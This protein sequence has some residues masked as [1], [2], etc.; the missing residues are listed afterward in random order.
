MLMFDPSTSSSQHKQL[1]Y[2]LLASITS[3]SSSSSSCGEVEVE[4]W[5]NYIRYL[6]QKDENF[7][8]I[9]RLFNFAFNFIDK[10]EHYHNDTFIQLCLL[11]AHYFGYPPPPPPSLAL[12]H[13]PLPSA[14]NME[15]IQEKFIEKWKR[16]KLELCVQ[17]FINLGVSSKENMT[18]PWRR[19]SSGRCLPLPP[20]LHSSFHSPLRCAHPEV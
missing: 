13:H 17:N 4:H 14:G 11:K 19:S 2:N 3:P 12:V 20:P 16:R 18:S 10:P 15:R 9:C 6:T 5:S 1:L 7:N 8:S